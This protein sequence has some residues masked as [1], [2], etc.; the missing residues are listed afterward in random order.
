MKSN[1]TKYM[2]VA[3]TLFLVTTIQS[4]QANV[5]WDNSRNTP[6][7]GFEKPFTP[8]DRSSRSTAPSKTPWEIFQSSNNGNKSPFARSANRSKK[9]ENPLINFAPPPN[10]DGD[11]QKLPVHGGV[12]ILAGLAL[13]YGV[14]CKKH[15]KQ[16][17]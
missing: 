3:V 6:I 5:Q 7:N 10:E 14:V 9:T 16:T 1:L 15:K 2:I 17:K 8:T 12:W 4:L 13:T 11:G